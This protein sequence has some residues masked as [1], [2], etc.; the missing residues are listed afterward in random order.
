MNNSNNLL[1]ILRLFFDFLFPKI[2][3]ICRDK[4]ILEKN[5]SPISNFCCF[6]C[7]NSMKLAAPPNIII[8][9]LI[10]SFGDSDL[11]ALSNIA[12]LY[13]A[14]NDDSNAIKLVYGL[15]YSGFRKIGI[16]FGQLLGKLLIDYNMTEYDYIA[17][18]PIHKARKRERGFNQSDF[19]ANGITNIIN[20]P[21]KLDLL[22]K[23]FYTQTQTQ[24]NS[25]QRKTNIKNS[26]MVNN[27]YDLTNKQILLVDDVLTTGATLNECATVLLE[28]KAKLVDAATIIK[29]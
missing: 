4:I 24:L 21:V 16:E 8:N 5:N 23:K 29:S 20:I 6:R 22:E 18:V 28:A 14:T 27:K 2:C 12:S 1:Y 7:F 15:K 9:N 19:I 13:S 3:L 26:F 11:L 10:A 17:P 25:K